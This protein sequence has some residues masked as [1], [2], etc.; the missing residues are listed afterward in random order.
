ME[1]KIAR[2]LGLPFH[3]VSLIWTNREPEKARKFR[4]GK[5]GCVMWLF[6]EVARKGSMAVFSKENFGCWGGGVGLGFGNRYADFPGGE[7][8]FSYFLS[9]GNRNH[10]TGRQVA[11]AL[12]D[13]A[14][15]SFLEEFLNGEGY[16]A[17]PEEVK[18]FL[19]LLPFREITEKYVV[20]CPLEKIEE[21][22]N[23]PRVVVFTAGPHQLAALI[24]L[25]NYNRKGIENVI[26]PYAAGCQT[27]GIFAYREAES[28]HPRAVMG[29]TDIS[30]RN[31]VR[32]HLG[33][34]V[35]TLALPWKLFQ[36]ME[37]NLK[38]SFV[39]RNTW[40][41]LMRTAHE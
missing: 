24:I 3:P 23:P 18:E 14:S 5:W 36:E 25:A 34:H 2:A 15:K 32:R 40:K 1:S 37:A 7:E 10:N 27:I 35:F 16:F 33:D 38:G 12:K 4:P 28:E 11:E 17:S 13:R 31:Y 8:C 39:E 29:L 20:M 9:T 41:E 21:F 26:V 6:A 19:Q 30:A 22:E